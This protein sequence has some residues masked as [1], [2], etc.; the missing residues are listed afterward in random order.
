MVTTART[1]TMAKVQRQPKAWLTAVA[2]GTPMTVATVRPSRMV[3]TARVRSRNGTSDAA[4]RAA[5]PK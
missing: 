3:E 5:T 4:T 1:L 2:T